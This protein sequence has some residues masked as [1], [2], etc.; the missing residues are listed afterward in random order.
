MPSED[1]STRIRL[2]EHIREA[3]RRAAEEQ[4]RSVNRQ[5]DR[6]V[7]QGLVR[8]GLLPGWPD[9]RKAPQ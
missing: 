4:Q 8:D 6:Y 5:V 7:R 1:G 9:D 2:P 3:L